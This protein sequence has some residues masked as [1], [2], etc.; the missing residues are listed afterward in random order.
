MDKDLAIATAR[1][2]CPDIQLVDT[3]FGFLDA[4]DVTARW[5]A[6]GISFDRY[7]YEMAGVPFA[8]KDKLVITRDLAREMALY[9]RLNQPEG[10]R[11][12]HQKASDGTRAICK[13]PALQQVRLLNIKPMTE[14]IFDW[15]TVMEKADELHFIDS[16]FANLASQLHIGTKCFR[17]YRPGYEDD[18]LYPVLNDQWLT[19]K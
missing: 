15:L 16:C 4:Q 14:S 17:Y 18:I 11:L 7:K 10:F 13:E 19:I 5:Q 1:R 8:E 9:N 6:S 2:F 12:L 3:Y